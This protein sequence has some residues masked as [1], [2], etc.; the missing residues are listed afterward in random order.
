MKTYNSVVDVIIPVYKPG[1]ELMDLLKK[2]STQ[3][4]PINR[5]I[6][7]NTEE[8]Y[9]SEEYLFLPRTEVVHITGIEFDHAA[10]RNMGMEMSSADKVLFMTMDAIPANDFM[11]EELVKSFDISSTHREQAAV[12]Y[13]RQLP[14]DD[15]RMAE[16]YARLFNYPAEGCVKTQ[17]DISRLGIKTY[18]C[19]DVCAMYDV[20]VYR[21]LGGFVPR[22]IFNEDMIYAAKAIQ[23]G[24]AIV[25]CANAQVIH[26]H[27][28]TIKQQ[29][30]RN[31]D[32]GVS[33]AEHP[34]VFA[35]VKSESEGIR[36]VKKTAG[37]LLRNGCWYQL[38]YLLFSSAAKYLGYK[39][40]LNYRKLSDRRILKCTMNKEYWKV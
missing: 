2:L 32:L 9:F 17:K 24:Y 16:Q 21:K 27:N 35:T 8:K 28:Y 18:F 22:A 37:Y 1:R 4:Y 29:F 20:S 3:T 34:E 38:P 11:V 13:G 40:G 33:Q 39:K 26:S 5:I 36:M 6:L 30:A 7:I 15:C 14:R 10:T 23:N 31:F 12:S 19:S 25:Y